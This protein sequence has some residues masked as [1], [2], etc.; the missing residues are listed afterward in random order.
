MR[1]KL[2]GSLS[3]ISGKP[4]KFV[5]QF[6]CLDNNI[7]YSKSYI[8]IQLAKA[9]NAIDWLLIIAKSNLSVKIKR[10]FFQTA[11]VSMDTNEMR[12]KKAK[13]WLLKNFVCYFEQI[14]EATPHKTTAV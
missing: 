11:K 2:K 10:N 1:F 12:R 7:L 13:W 14:L 4:L 5:D 3:T 6:T 9:S 8:N